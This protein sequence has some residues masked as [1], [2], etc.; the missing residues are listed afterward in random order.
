LA[1]TVYAAGRNGAVEVTTAIAAG[2]LAAVGVHV[3]FGEYVRADAVT[4]GALEAET[5]A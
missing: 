3:C 2:G 1:S 5:P 4:E